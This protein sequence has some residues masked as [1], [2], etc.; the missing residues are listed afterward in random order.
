MKLLDDCVNLISWLF[1]KVYSGLF[2]VHCSFTKSITSIYYVNFTAGVKVDISS[3]KLH[4]RKH[5]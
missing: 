5:I 1:A 4:N 2:I 3:K